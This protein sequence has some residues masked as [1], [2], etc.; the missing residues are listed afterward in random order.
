MV[1]LGAFLI[2]EQLNAAPFQLDKAEQLAFMRHYRAPQAE[3]SAFYI[4]NANSED[5]PFGYYELDAMM[6]G[7]HLS[8]PTVN[9]YSGFEPHRAFTLIP[10]GVEYKYRVLD[11]LQEQGATDRICELDYQSG[12]FVQVDVIGERG[13][14]RELYLASL[15]QTFS[16]LYEAASKFVAD[17]NSLSNMYPQYLE[18]HGYLDAALGHE[19]GP[20][21][22]WMQGRYW[23]G[24]KACDRGP[25]FGIAVVGSYSE[26]QRI[27]EAYGGLA[28]RVLF[29]DPQEW[30]P[31][32]S[33]AE[34]AADELLMIFTAEETGQ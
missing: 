4:N 9:G 2:A 13:H 21:Y 6:I 30:Q 16:T 15:L 7:M 3:C 24:E 8:I 32:K 29:P 34:N 19:T 33:L 5:L 20:R 17:G 22:K 26:V 25:C 18:E 14:Y 28:I 23:I 10:K 31:G 1:I 11:W 12:A 27:L